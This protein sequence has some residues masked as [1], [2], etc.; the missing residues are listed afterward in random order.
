MK[1]SKVYS[2]KDDG[3]NS[4]EE[5][6]RVK[7]I[8]RNSSERIKHEEYLTMLTESTKTHCK[9]TQF[10]CK[11]QKVSTIMFKKDCLSCYVDKRWICDDGILSYAH[12]HYRTK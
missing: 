3:D 5:K 6:R 12:G 9:I 7:D 11:N 2:H 8:N 10:K 4:I 1:W